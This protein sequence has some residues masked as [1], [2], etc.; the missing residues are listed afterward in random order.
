ML[1]GGYVEVM[2][3]LTFPL[4][5]AN[6]V[7]AYHVWHVGAKTGKATNERMAKTTEENERRRCRMRRSNSVSG[8]GVI[9]GRR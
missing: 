7:A 3:I 2:I 6:K 4:L 1:Q 8:G 9:I 5:A